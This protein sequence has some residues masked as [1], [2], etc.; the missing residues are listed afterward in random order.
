MVRMASAALKERQERETTPFRYVFVLT[1]ADKVDKK[2]LSASFKE[3]QSAIQGFTEN[4]PYSTHSSTHSSAAVGFGTS[5]VGVGF[6][7]VGVYSGVG[8]IVTSAVDRSGA[9]EVWEVIHNAVA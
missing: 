4:S 5:D 8:A 7:D 9:E 3:V 6:G 1:K 2:Q